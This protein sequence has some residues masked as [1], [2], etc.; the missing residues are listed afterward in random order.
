MIHI[1]RGCLERSNQLVRSDGSRIEGSHKGWNSIQR[2]MPSGVVVTVALSHDYVHRRNC[3]S[4]A[5]RKDK[6]PFEQGTYGSHHTQLVSSNSELWNTLVATQREPASEL[7]S[8]LPVLMKVESGE[9]FGLIAAKNPGLPEGLL[10]I[11]EEESKS[12]D[13]VDLEAIDAHAEDLGDLLETFSID[14]AILIDSPLPVPGPSNQPIGPIASGPPD[15]PSKDTA[16]ANPAT[17]VLGKRKA[18]DGDGDIPVIDVDEDE[19]AGACDQAPTVE[20]AAKRVHIEVSTDSYRHIPY[21]CTHLNRLAIWRWQDYHP[22]ILQCR[23]HQVSFDS[24]RHERW[25]QSTIIGRD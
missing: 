5:N 20:P 8:T 9:T 15:A 7:L 24:A 4:A 17:G 18:I 2:A 25:C 10:E 1:N 12:I 19:D 21:Q 14:P 3:R 13:E 11:K 22:G 23:K 16:K 6:T